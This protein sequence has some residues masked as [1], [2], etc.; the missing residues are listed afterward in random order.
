MPIFHRTTNPL[1]AHFRILTASR[2]QMI[3]I[4]EQD[5]W[6]AVAE[7]HGYLS[8]IETDAPAEC[9]ATVPSILR[10]LRAEGPDPGDSIIGFTTHGDSGL[11][12][13]VEALIRKKIET[14]IAK[15]NMFS[16]TD[17]NHEIWRNDRPEAAGQNC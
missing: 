16:A 10:M 3:A 9:Y 15:F 12:S 8:E 13:D 6:P 11:A 5:E 1:V 7:L 2:I 4:H 14:A 17:R